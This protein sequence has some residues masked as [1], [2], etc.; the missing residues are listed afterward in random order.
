METCSAAGEPAAADDLCLE[1]SMK[2]S[3]C[4]EPGATLGCYNKGCSFR[5]H[6][7]C[8]IDADCLLNEE[9][10]SVRCPKHKNKMVKGSLSTEQSER[11]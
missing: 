2:C 10:F 1:Q 4:Q 3:H 5:Y 6:Y 11:G 8:A 7:P 9:N